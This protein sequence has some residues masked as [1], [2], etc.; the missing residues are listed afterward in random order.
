MAADLVE[1]RRYRRTAKQEVHGLGT[2]KTKRGIKISR[3]GIKSEPP[4]WMKTGEKGLT[5]H[6]FDTVKAVPV[7][8]A[9]SIQGTH[10]VYHRAKPEH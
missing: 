5:V 3:C 9:V 1:L 10:I 7:G 2:R 4:N 8:I 6:S